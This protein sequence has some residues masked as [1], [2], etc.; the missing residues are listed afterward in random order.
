LDHWRTVK[1]EADEK[2]GNAPPNSFMPN[3]ENLVD[4]KK[5]RVNE[6]KAGIPEL[7]SKSTDPYEVW[8][9]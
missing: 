3:P 1:P 7:V 6:S 5:D 9:K 8:F 2:L 4:M